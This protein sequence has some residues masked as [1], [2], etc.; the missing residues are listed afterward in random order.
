MRNIKYHVIIRSYAIWPINHVNRN[1]PSF[2]FDYDNI[3]KFMSAHH[4]GWWCIQLMDNKLWIRVSKCAHFLLSYCIP[5]HLLNGLRITDRSLLQMML[6]SEFRTIFK[7]LQGWSRIENVKIYILF[8]RQY[9]GFL[10]WLLNNFM[11]NL[12]EIYLYN[13]ACYC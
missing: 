11:Y 10:K 8:L 7:V 13:N 4:D 9:R 2:K 12:K 6:I 1:W 3:L 5:I